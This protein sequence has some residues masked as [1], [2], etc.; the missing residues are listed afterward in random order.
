MPAEKPKNPVEEP[1]KVSSN[2]VIR[3]GGWDSPASYARVSD[4]DGDA[5]GTRD[6]NLGFRI[7]G[8][9]K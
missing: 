5:P 8:T 6:F 1:E 4:R 2:R 3:G 9:K 7:A